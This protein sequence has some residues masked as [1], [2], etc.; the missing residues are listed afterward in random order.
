MWAISF[1]PKLIQASFSGSTKYTGRSHIR[2]TSDMDQRLGCTW[3]KINCN[4]IMLPSIMLLSKVMECVDCGS[5]MKWSGIFL[6]IKPT[7]RH[8]MWPST[9]LQLTDPLDQC[10]ERA[11][12][13]QPV[14]YRSVGQQALLLLQAADLPQQLLLQLSEAAL[15][16]VTQ[17]A[18]ERRARYVGPHLLLLGEK[19][20]NM[21]TGEDTETLEWWWVSWDSTS[22]WDSSARFFCQNSDHTCF[23]FQW[24]LDLFVFLTVGFHHPENLHTTLSCTQ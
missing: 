2:G 12:G 5:D 11:L 16:Q 1:S 3:P 10:V 24:T 20:Q 23:F 22:N 14:G 17:L 8:S 7:W 19:V 4:Q 21:V 18:G 6:T 9:F 13:L 15:Q